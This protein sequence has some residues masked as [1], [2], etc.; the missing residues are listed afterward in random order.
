MK[1]KVSFVKRSYYKIVFKQTIWRVYR[2]TRNDEDY[3]NY[4]EALNLA[5][6]EIR[7]YKRTFQQKLAGNI[8]NYSKSFYAYVRSKQKVR[9]KVGSLENNSGNIISDGFQMAEVLDEYF[10]SVFAT[11][12][13]SSLPVPFS[14]FE[15]CKSE[16]LRQFKK[17]KDNKSPEVDGIPPKLLKEIVEQISTP[18]AKLFNLSLEEGMV[19]SEWK[20]ANITPLFKKGSR[21][22]LQN[23]RP[24][25]L[26]S[27]CKLLETLIRDHMVEVLVK[28]KLINTSQH[29]F[30]K[31][32]SCLTNLLCFLEEI[33]KWVDDG[34]PV[35]VVYLDFQKA[36]NKV[37]HQR[38]LLKLKTHGIGND[39]INWIEEWLTHRRQRVIVDGEI[40]NWKS[41]LSGIPQGHGNMD[42]EYKMGDAVLGRTTQEKDL[43][44]TFSADMNVSEQCG[45][46]ASKGNQILGL[47]RRTI[48]YKEKQLIVPLYKA[49]VN[50]IWNIVFK[51][52]GRNVNRT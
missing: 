40:S 36:F 13:I 25:S 14:K 9:D 21:N 27:M 10:S 50:H 26:T 24:V 4:K 48:M 41:V 2:R 32:R 23:Y 17:M 34:S 1:L 16:H 39:V 3:A 18:L 29:G 28:H 22:K 44:V 37:P 45:I 52:G 19:P 49:I 20:E 33:T 30:L 46:A 51:H 8:K 43:G 7:K 35:D 15:A 6:T 31:A 5:T 11:E 42:E 12:D 47:I 38:L